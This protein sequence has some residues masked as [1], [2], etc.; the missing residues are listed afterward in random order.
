MTNLLDIVSVNQNIGNSP[1]PIN[2]YKS[3]ANK[4]IKG[5]SILIK[6][7]FGETIVFSKEAYM[8]LEIVIRKRLVP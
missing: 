6:D 1:T 8:A 4:Y 5:G 7:Q 2:V 3:L